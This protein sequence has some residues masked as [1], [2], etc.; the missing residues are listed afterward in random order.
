MHSSTLA[1]PP[2]FNATRAR[3]D[4]GTALAVAV[5]AHGL[6]L[7]AKPHTPPVE[8]LVRDTSVTATTTATPAEQDKEEV[9][10]ED[11]DVT[12]E[13]RGK[14]GAQGVIY[15]PSDLIAPTPGVEILIDPRSISYFKLNHPATTY[16]FTP[17]GA[18]IIPGAIDAGPA[19]P[20][21]YEVMNLEKVPEAV[22]RE[23]PHCPN[24]LINE[25]GS[26][27]V[28]AQFV[29]LADG[30]VTGIRIIS[31]SHRG[32][33]AGVEKALARWKFKPGWRKGVRVATRMEQLFTF[34]PAD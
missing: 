15:D 5:I 34:S 4:F 13:S 12:N 17:P 10:I 20:V 30:T 28:R 23:K 19:G 24:A 22:Y 1:F 33:E 8:R 9:T 18:T 31:S 14:G 32:F 27:T 16:E 2:A 11:L 29:V 7:L 26:A 6:L 21:I 25:V 3:R